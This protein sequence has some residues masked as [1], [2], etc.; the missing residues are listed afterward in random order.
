MFG[1]PADLIVVP[2]ST[3]GKVTRLVQDRMERFA[4]P[5]VPA[6]IP[7]GEVRLLP[8]KGA[9]HVA[10]F[11]AYAASVRGSGSE[12]E[13]IERIGEKLGHATQQE[14]VQVIHCPLLG[15]GA[16]ALP[17]EVAF[18]QLSHGSARPVRTA[19]C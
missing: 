11:V 13:A 15:A 9:D 6:P 10:Q 4:L 5:P 16:G 12:L 1:G 14:S 17:G 19:R 3:A 2:C 8:L 18:A 7:L